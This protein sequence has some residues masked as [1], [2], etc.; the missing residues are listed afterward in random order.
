VTSTASTVS[1]NN[2]VTAYL[3]SHCFTAITAINPSLK[4]LS[5][6]TSAVCNSRLVEAKVVL[7]STNYH[8]VKTNGEWGYSSTHS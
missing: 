7:C 3:T 5:L 6:P 8:A 2:D 4:Y 1:L